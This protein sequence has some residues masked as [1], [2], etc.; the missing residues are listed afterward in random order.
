MVAGLVVGLCKQK[1]LC[2]SYKAVFISKAIKI[3]PV[4]FI[5]TLI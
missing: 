4:S 3:F 5:F 2:I 1:I